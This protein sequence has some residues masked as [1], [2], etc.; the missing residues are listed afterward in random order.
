MQ[1]GENTIRT[2]LADI[3]VNVACQGPEYRTRLYERKDY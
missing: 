3:A 1:A 2:L